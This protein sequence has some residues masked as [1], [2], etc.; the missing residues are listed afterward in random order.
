MGAEKLFEK[1]P[2]SAPQS[3]FKRPRISANR[4]RAALSVDYPPTNR[5]AV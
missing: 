4:D 2:R 1:S 5:A 3:V